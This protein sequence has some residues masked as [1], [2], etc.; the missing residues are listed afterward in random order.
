MSCTEILSQLELV[1]YL[2]TQ[3]ET[4][5]GGRRE[6]GRVKGKGEG[7]TMKGERDKERE[8][9]EREREKERER[10]IK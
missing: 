10:K 5:R 8:G 1:T 9:G 2:Q 7:E 6:G 4:V 3:S